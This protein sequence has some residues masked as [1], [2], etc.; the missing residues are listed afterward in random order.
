MD[1][2]ILMKTMNIRAEKE[3]LPQ[4]E[5]SWQIEKNFLTRSLNWRFKMT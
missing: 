4:E 2:E 1:L 3:N 5:K